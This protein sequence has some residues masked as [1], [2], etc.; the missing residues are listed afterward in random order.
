MF[1]YGIEVLL[2]NPDL[3]AEL[4]GKRVSLVAHPA[5]VNQQLAHSMDLLHRHDDIN[6]TCAFGPQHGLRGEKQD[7][8]IESDDYVDPKV[9]KPVFSLYGRVRRPTKEM[10]DEFDVVLFDLQDVGCRIYTFLTTLFY[11]MD[12]CSQLGKSIW[13]LDRPNPAG[14]NIEGLILDMSFETFIGAAPVPM[15]H[16]LTLGEAARWYAAHK[17]YDIDLKVVGMEDYSMDAVGGYGWPSQLSWVNPSPNMPRLSCSRMYAGTVLLEGTLLSE[18]RGSTLPLEMFGAPNM[19]GEKILKEM[20]KINEQWL[21]GCL[22]RPTYF[23]P[24]FHKH[25]GQLCAGLQIHIDHPSYRHDEFYPF[26]LI[27]GYLKAVRKLYPDF[28]LWKQPP[29]EYEEEKLP[30]DILSGDQQ[31]RTW[32]EDEGARA[33]DWDQKLKGHESRWSEERAPYL[34]Y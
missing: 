20:Q 18:G 16:G 34:L 31:L 15:R 11:M 25:T 3:L 29:Y 6:L 14:R 2:D 21:R 4:K 7:N 13:I 24:T 22:L 17:N 27:C 30:I 5:S 8:M 32:V 23:E 10:M 19:D 33:Y 28:E 1:K 26:R 9:G 12:E